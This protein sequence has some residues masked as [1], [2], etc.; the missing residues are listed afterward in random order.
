VFRALGPYFADVEYMDA[1]GD[2]V[3]QTSNLFGMVST[4]LI[5]V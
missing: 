2:T 4:C 3:Q 1:L 5:I